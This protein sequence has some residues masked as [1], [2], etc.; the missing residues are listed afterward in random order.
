MSVDLTLCVLS[1]KTYVIQD[2]GIVERNMVKIVR[3][4]CMHDT[5]SGRATGATNT[6]SVSAAWRSVILPCDPGIT[7]V[8]KAK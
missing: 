2:S 3:S 4:P 1:K 7:T 8:R 6:V 5:R